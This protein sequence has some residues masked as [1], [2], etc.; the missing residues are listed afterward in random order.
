MKICQ[1]HWDQCR[2]AIDKHGMADL[3]AKDG[4]QAMGA[5]QRT[6]QTGTEAKSDFDPL[7]SMHWH[8]MN[9]ALRAGGLYL[10]GADPEPNNN[11]GHYCPMCEYGKHSGHKAEDAIEDI[12]QQ[13]AAWCRSEG[14]I[15]KVS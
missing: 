2:A 15:P 5:L 11:D 10:M 13:I 4:E 7:M 9:T 8:W 14:L 6:L 12:A 3:V 1:T